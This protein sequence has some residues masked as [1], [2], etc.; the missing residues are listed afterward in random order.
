MLKHSNLDMAGW[1]WGW[2]VSSCEALYVTALAQA[3][4]FLL[5]YPL[6][7]QGEFFDGSAYVHLAFST[8][9]QWYEIQ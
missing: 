1:G 8:H 9:A 6:S 3:G 7:L 5:V 2:G 4:A